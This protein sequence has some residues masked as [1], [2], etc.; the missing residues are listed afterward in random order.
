MFALLIV[1]LVLAKDYTCFLSA[2]VIPG[3]SR[4]IN[5][6]LTYLSTRVL[7]CCA[8]LEG[9]PPSQ[10]YSTTPQHSYAAAPQSSYP[11]VQLTH[12]SDA[13]PDYCAGKLLLIDITSQGGMASGQA[14][15][16]RLHV[17]VCLFTP[18]LSLLFT[19]TSPGG[20]AG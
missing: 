2:S 5:S 4:V 20:M 10:Q 17:V 15:L 13:P 6:L 9:Y 19:V 8:C 18:Q 7:E 11:P 3:L 12:D 1:S 14:E 16:A